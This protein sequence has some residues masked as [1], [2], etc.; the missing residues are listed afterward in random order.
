M[1]EYIYMIKQHRHQKDE[2]FANQSDSP[3]EKKDKIGFEGLKYFPINEKFSFKNIKM[4]EF[5]NPKEKYL[6]ERSA[7]DIQDYYIFGRV[8]FLVNEENYELLVYTNPE[9]GN[10][11]YFVPFWDKTALS[12]ETYGGGRY[13]ELENNPDGT[14]TLDFNLA[15]NPY[16]VYSPHYSCPLIPQRNRLEVKIE[17]GEKNFK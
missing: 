11:Y 8:L 3:L 13:L 5:P 4:L 12:G 1:S 14:F 2:F 16:C 6:M 15:Y 9:V 7:G 10:D 17:A